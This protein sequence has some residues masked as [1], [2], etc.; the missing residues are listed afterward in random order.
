MRTISFLK[1]AHLPSVEEEKFSSVM[2]SKA[3]SAASIPDFI[4]V[5]VPLILGTFINPGLQP[6][7]SPPGNANFGIHYNGQW[8][9]ILQILNINPYATILV[10]GCWFHCPDK[11]QLPLILGLEYCAFVL[12]ARGEHARTV[13]SPPLTKVGPQNTRGENC[14]NNQRR[15][16]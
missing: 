13:T 14:C 2:A 3:H 6:I 1:L 10:R 5:W 15:G 9:K 16:T 11:K 12:F 7:R 8:N 4:A